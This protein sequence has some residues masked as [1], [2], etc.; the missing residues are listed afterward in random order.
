[1]VLPQLHPRWILRAVRG[2]VRAAHHRERE[3]EGRGRNELRAVLPTGKRPFAGRNIST[4]ARCRPDT[5]SATPTVATKN[6]KGTNRTGSLFVP[7]VLF[8]AK[9]EYVVVDIL[10]ASH[11]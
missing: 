3:R 11:L 9:K 2:D 6:T 10:S 7:F 4:S 1:M 5:L 8:V